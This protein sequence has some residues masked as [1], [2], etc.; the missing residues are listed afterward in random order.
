MKHQDEFDAPGMVSVWIGN[1]QT[2]A[3]FDDYMNLSREFEA[4]FGFNINSQ[5]VREA[6]VEKQAKP[7]GELVVGFSSW[8]SFGS[9]VAEAAKRAGVERATTMTVFYSCR[10]DP[11]KV[12][13]SPN[14][15]L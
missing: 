12:K 2:D 7:V 3:Q 10:F 13:I 11:T 6:T 14:A 5:S 8:E 4:D 1:F 9:E 15:L